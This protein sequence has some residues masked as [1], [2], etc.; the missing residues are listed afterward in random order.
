MTKSEKRIQKPTSFRFSPSMLEAL[1]ELVETS[2]VK[3][4]GLDNKTQW[5]TH[6]FANFLRMS[7]RG[8]IPA[9]RLE[10][11]RKPD[12]VFSLFVAES[13]RTKAKA[14]GTDELKSMEA[15]Y[16]QALLLVP[17]TFFDEAKKRLIRAELKRRGENV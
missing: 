1:D 3:M 10:A 4:P 11:A 2:L 15:E 6:I 5:L 12:D 14:A 8:K 9:A 16:L 7:L 13:K 17:K